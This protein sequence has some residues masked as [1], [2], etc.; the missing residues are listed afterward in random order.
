MWSVS[1][2]RCRPAH[3]SVTRRRTRVPLSPWPTA[4]QP[5]PPPSE[6]V[7]TGA[8]TV[9]ET[10]AHREPAVPPRVAPRAT[11]ATS[12]AGCNA[13]AFGRT[14]RRAAGDAPRS[15]H[16]CR[17]RCRCTGRTDIGPVESRAGVA[18]GARAASTAP[19]GGEGFS[20]SAVRVGEPDRRGA[21]Q[22]SG[23]SEIEIASS[24]GS[25]RPVEHGCR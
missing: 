24:R 17:C 15:S 20:L 21:A 5:C 2:R 16:R 12:R 11:P 9:D 25:A 18:A 7:A 14:A 3:P 4:A 6:S 10:H 8:P 13:G 23:L 22:A 19:W 1:W